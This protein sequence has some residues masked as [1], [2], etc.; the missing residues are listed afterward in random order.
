MRVQA[1]SIGSPLLLTRV[2]AFTAVG[3]ALGMMLSGVPNVELVTAV[4]FMSG[5]LLGLWG[6][7]LTGG[8]TEALFAGFHP[9]GSS[10]GLLL[11]AQV[12]GMMITGAL[13]AAV[14]ASCSKR[15]GLRYGITIGFSGIVSTLIF[16][17]LTNLAFPIMAGFSFS[18]TLVTLIAG[19]PFAAI[20]IASNLLVFIVIVRTVIPR[21][22]KAW[23]AI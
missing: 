5:F 15:D 17:I 10:L 3:V 9:M 22:E 18:Q 11:V 13:G 7:V 12:V 4:C 1:R 16:D 21:L 6:G 20:H 8:L 14:A 23:L 2:A 19:I